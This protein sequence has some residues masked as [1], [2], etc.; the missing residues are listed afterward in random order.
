VALLHGSN[1][2]YEAPFVNTGEEYLPAWYGFSANGNITAPYVFAN[3]GYEEDFEAL[4]QANV[5][6]TGKIAMLKIADV[7]PY[8]REKGSTFFGPFK[9]ETART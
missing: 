4:V 1:V 5:S 2:L 6:L 8:L 3:F 7:S 9:S